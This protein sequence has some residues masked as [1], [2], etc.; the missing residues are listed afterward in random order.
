MRPVFIAGV[1]G[2]ILILIAYGLGQSPAPMLIEVDNQSGRTI[3]HILVQKG[4]GE[5]EWPGVVSGQSALISLNTEEA[6]PVSV[7]L[8]LKAGLPLAMPEA[9][10]PSLE[11]GQRLY[12]RLE[13]SGALVVKVV[14]GSGTVDPASQ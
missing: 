2:L 4:D 11:A 5:T 14:R 7:Q 8:L 13:P 12:I 3:E 10:V 9:T 6:T 1:V